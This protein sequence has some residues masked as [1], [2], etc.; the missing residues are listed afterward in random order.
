MAFTK[1]I[2]GNPKGRTQG[3]QNKSTR[4]TKE[5]LKSILEKHLTEIQGEQ[6]LSIQDKIALIRT[7]LPYTNPK[8]QSIVVHEGDKFSAFKT[9]DINII[10]PNEDK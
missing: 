4:E 2:S 6:E 7:I 9:I 8:L 5:M 10:K 1:G 3:V